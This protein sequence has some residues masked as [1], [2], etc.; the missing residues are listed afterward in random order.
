MQGCSLAQRQRA[1]TRFAKVGPVVYPPGVTLGPLRFPLFVLVSLAGMASCKDSSKSPSACGTVDADGGVVSSADGTLTLSFRPGSVSETTEVCISEAKSEAAGGP[2]APYGQAYRVKPDIELGA[3]I[4]ATYRASLPDDTS[5]VAVGVIRREDFE[6][7]QGQWLALPVT[8][9]EPDNDLVAGTDTRLS[10]FYGLLDDGGAGPASGSDTDSDTEGD[11]D[12]QG[13]DGSTTTPATG[14]GDTSS[15]DG[16]T[17]SGPSTG[18]DTTTAGESTSESTGTG[19]TGESDSDTGPDPVDCD[20]LPA[21][22]YDIVQIATVLPGNS[23]DLAMTGSGTFIVADGDELVE[24]D[25]EGGASTWLAGIPYDDDIL[26]IAFHPDGTLYGAMGLNGTGLL[27]FTP[28]GSTPLLVGEFQLPNGVYV[29]HDGI[30]WV[31]DYFGASIQR[32]DPAGPS[33]EVV[34]SSNANNANG[35][36]HDEERGQLFWTNYNASQLW[37]APVTGASV[38]TPVP[39]ADLE[40]RSDGV[41]MDECGNIY[42]LDQGGTAGN[43]PCRID[44]VPLDANGDAAG[45]TVEIAEAGDLGNACANMQFGYGFGNAYD[46]SGFVTGQAGNIYRIDLGVGGYDVTLPN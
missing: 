14:T 11:T 45:A 12:S 17:T 8:R 36:F 31:T 37:R 16:E 18:D 24:M 32:V 22:P 20:N 6:A 33:T 10:M 27:A 34:V 15:T 29:D 9:L 21:P 1:P 2:P 39:V 44:R 30:V 3:N 28:G 42:V 4:S 46:R 19:T 35:V 7:G 5:Q 25:G 43:I 40:G 23:E 41:A 13:S 26:G 38:G